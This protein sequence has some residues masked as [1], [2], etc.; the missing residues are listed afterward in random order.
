[1]APIEDDIHIWN[2]DFGTRIFRIHSPLFH[3]YF[4]ILRVSLSRS[5]GGIKENGQERCF[6]RGLSD[7]TVPPIVCTHLFFQGGN[8]KISG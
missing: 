7:Y 5:E 8:N 3:G 1:M 6:L 2:I 4:I